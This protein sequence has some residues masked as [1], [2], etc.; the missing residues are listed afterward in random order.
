MPPTS[1][2]AS[3]YDSATAGNALSRVDSGQTENRAV[4]APMAR[5]R[6]SKRAASRRSS[7]LLSSRLE[8]PCCSTTK[9]HPPRRRFIHAF[10]K[11]SQVGQERL[12]LFGSRPPVEVDAVGGGDRWHHT[13][14]GICLDPLEQ[15][16]VVVDDFFE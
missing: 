7:T 15:L 16:D 6:A 9:L 2:A 3:E 13:G 8:G 4:R 10:S 12:A 11:F 5:M 1:C 14:R